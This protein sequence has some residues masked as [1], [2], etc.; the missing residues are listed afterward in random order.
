MEVKSLKLSSVHPSPM[1]PRKTFDEEALKELSENIRQQG[2]LQPITVRPVADNTEYEIVCGERRYRAYRILAEEA[3]LNNDLPFNPWDEI[4]AI[5]K[6]MSDEEAFDA[7]ITENLQRQDVDPMEEAFAF[8]QLQKKGKSIQEIA[9]RFGKSVRFVQDRIKLNALIPELMKELKEDNMP[10]SAAMVICKVDEDRQRAYFKQYKDSYK[11]FTTASAMSFVKAMFLTL[12][13]AV[14]K[15]NPEFAGGCDTACGQCPHNTAN[16][17]CLFYEMK[18]KDDGQCTNSERYQAKT[19][20]YIESYLAEI[21]DTLVRAGEPLEKG[22]TVIAINIDGYAPES[23][24][25]LKSAIRDR[26][27]ALGYEIVEPDKIFNSRCFYDYEDERTQA[28]LESGECY[29]VLQLASYNYIRPELLTYYVK[30]G[31]T[32]TNVDNSGRPVKVQELL[33]KYKQAKAVLQASYIVQGCKALVEHGNSASVGLEVSEMNLAYAL[34]IKSSRAIR[35]E[36]RLDEFCSDNDIINFINANT[37]PKILCRI[38]RGWIKKQLDTGYTIT[39]NEAIHLAEPYLESIATTWCPEHFRE[40]HDKVTEKF[41]KS[42][43]KITK[44]LADLG[45]T[46]DGEK[47]SEPAP[48]EE[49]KPAKL[50]V[51]MGKVYKEMKKKHPDSIIIFRVGDFYEIINEDAEKAAKVLNITITKRGKKMLCGF[52]HHALDT[53]LPKLVTAGLKVAICEQLEDP[54]K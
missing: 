32:T 38:M 29:R 13:D 7:M 48:V 51:S 9:D 4:M 15:D 30:K 33:N 35:K 27:S 22:K 47:I 6:E 1:N 53:Y 23:V 40:A 3:A 42:V 8:G 45:Y 41:D 54:K 24:K 21:S 16:H 31:D 39:P 36:L 49:P 52:P 46:L 25:K 44:Q 5:V 28:F 19:V 10:I 37:D 2:L 14:W 50:P 18:A 12:C 34:M 20:A 26:V 17:G 11:G 43:A